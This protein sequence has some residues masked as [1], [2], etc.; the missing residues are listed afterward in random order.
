AHLEV[1]REETPELASHLEDLHAQ[2]LF[3]R[4][5]GDHALAGALSQT[6]ALTA[7][8]VRLALERSPEAPVEAP[9]P[10]VAEDAPAEAEAEAEPEPPPAARAPRRRPRR[11][12]EEP[13]EADE[14]EPSAAVR[15]R[16]ASVAQ[17]SAGSA[18]SERATQALLEADRALAEGLT[19]RAV[20]L[21]DDAERALA[22]AEPEADESYAF[23]RDARRRLG[24]LA[25]VRGDSVS[26]PL[27]SIFSSNEGTWRT[28]RPALVSE[29]RALA[30][31][32][33][34]RTLRLFMRERSGA[35]ADGSDALID[36]LVERFQIA[37]ERIQF[38]G[39]RSG[40]QAACMLVFTASAE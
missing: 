37:R 3:H 33:R 8:S 15:E 25:V 11:A 39:V 24:R 13:V 23:V 30:R 40:Q 12:P 17:R 14:P 38:G 34:G 35:F 27:D 29:L 7:L 10:S 18:S 20:E 31:G 5:R 26:V 16:L 28:N 6:V 2:A 22:G 1:L 9:A 32:Y 4:E 21:I 19:E 36:A